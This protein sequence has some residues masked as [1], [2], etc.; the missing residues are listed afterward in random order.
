MR[1]EDLS[2]VPTMLHVSVGLVCK[3]WNVLYVIYNCQ[4]HLNPGERQVSE[5]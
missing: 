5:I 2:T 3:E 4:L 1:G